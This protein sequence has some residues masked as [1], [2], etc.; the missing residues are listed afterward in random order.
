MEKKIRAQE[1]QEDHH[2]GKTFTHK[3]L[4]RSIRTERLKQ[5]GLNPK[6]FA[7]RADYELERICKLH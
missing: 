5:K 7:N 1:E 6:D 3:D 4:V 2:K